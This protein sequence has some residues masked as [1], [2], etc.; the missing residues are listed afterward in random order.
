MVYGTR[1]APK[2][3]VLVYQRGYYLLNKWSLRQGEPI[4]ITK[5]GVVVSELLICGNRGTMAYCISPGSVIS[6]SESW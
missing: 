1:P 6:K 2:E 3:L 5:Y 4:L